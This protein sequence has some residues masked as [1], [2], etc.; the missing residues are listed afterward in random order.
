MHSNSLYFFIDSRP[1]AIQ[2]NE[3]SLLKINR[4]LVILTN[5]HVLRNKYNNYS[6][7]KSRTI[8]IFLINICRDT[9]NESIKLENRLWVGT[10]HRKTFHKRTFH[11]WDCSQKDRPKIRHFIDKTFHSQDSSKKDISQ[12]D[13]SQSDISYIGQFI[14]IEFLI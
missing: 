14:G 6:L 13:I 5:I 7:Q 3:S 1:A 9:S 10:F 12:S 4:E 8:V 11:S 2:N